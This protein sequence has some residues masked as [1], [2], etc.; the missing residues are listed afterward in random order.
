MRTCLLLSLLLGAT[1]LSAPVHAYVPENTQID[2]RTIKPMM[3]WVEHKMGVKV[4][5]YPTVIANQARLEEGAYNAKAPC[6]G[7]VLAI[8][9]P[10]TVILD[11]AR[12]QASDPIQ[13]SI[14][15]HELV[16]HAQFYMKKQNWK[17]GAR[18]QQAY[19]LQ[20]RWLEE[21]NVKPFFTTA[22][23]NK[24]SGLHID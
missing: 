15:V 23:I 8:Y 10:G 16:H 2:S 18:E 20:N 22:W 9:V 4:P 1:L 19:R 13:L 17:P 6:G 11:N 24:A 14:L 5:V 12:W 7:E 3:D 21:H